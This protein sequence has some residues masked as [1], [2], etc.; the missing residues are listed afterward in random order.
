LFGGQKLDASAGFCVLRGW[1]LQLNLFFLLVQLH[2]IFCK[3]FAGRRSL[4]FLSL[5]VM[6]LAGAVSRA[7]LVA[8]IVYLAARICGSWT[9]SAK[10]SPVLGLFLFMQYTC[11]IGTKLLFLDA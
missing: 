6:L 2:C 11:I 1:N 3:Y 10:T 9:N 7:S 4:R 5:C 8:I